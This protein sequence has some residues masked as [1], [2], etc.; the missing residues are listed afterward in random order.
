MKLNCKGDAYTEIILEVFKLGGL[1]VLEGDRITRP[2]G[3]SSARWKILGALQRAGQ[4]LSAAQIARAMGQSRQGV[5]RLVNELHEEEL[6]E[7]ADNPNHKR[8]KLIS[9]SGKGLAVFSELEILQARWANKQSND[10]DNAALETTLTTLKEMSGG[11][12]A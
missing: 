9:L 4:A 8:A 7:F 5:Q 2:L 12:E 3:L 11:L 10:I 6:L 1:L